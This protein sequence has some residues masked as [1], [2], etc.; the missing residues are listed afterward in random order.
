MN[1]A[2]HYIEVTCIK[3]RLKAKHPV[4]GMDYD[5]RAVCPACGFHLFTA[6]QAQLELRQAFVKQQSEF[7]AHEIANQ[8]NQ[9]AAK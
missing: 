6:P 8:L 4:I 2:T 5:A 3:C 9:R 1:E 7:E